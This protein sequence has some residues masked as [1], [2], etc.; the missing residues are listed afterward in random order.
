VVHNAKQPFQVHA[1]GQLIQDIGTTFDVNVYTD[2]PVQRTT[3]I[4]GA[5]KIGQT[6]LK[7]G[8]QA[9]VKAGKLSVAKADIQMV[10]AWK[11]G[12]F[13]FDNASLEDIMRQ[14]SRWYDVEI[15]YEGKI[16]TLR[17]GGGIAR[18]STAQ[19]VLTILE[20]SNIHFK[21]K[22]QKIIVMP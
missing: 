16:P 21:I 11:N 22:N 1:G 13:L 4:E 10:S 7:P 3:L 5:I 2:E 8:Q 15:S 9:R 14:L 20:Q 19:Q 17:F 12:Y 18:S 6:L